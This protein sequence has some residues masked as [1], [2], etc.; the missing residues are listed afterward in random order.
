M[1][2]AATYGLPSHMYSLQDGLLLSLCCVTRISLFTARWGTTAILRGS[3]F[4]KSPQECFLFFVNS[5]HAC[6]SLFS[7]DSDCGTAA[8]NDKEKSSTKA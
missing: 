5:C 2:F 4:Y 8:L 1:L 6:P 7:F 3:T